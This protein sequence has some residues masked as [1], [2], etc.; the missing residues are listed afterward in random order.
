MFS[1]YKRKN[2]KSPKILR[3]F[4][5]QKLSPHT[6]GVASLDLAYPPIPNDPKKNLFPQL[7]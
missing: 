6:F 2:G 3:F 4:G 1:S 7:M 5:H